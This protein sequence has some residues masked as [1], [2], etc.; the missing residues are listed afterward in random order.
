MIDVPAD[1]PAHVPA[2][3]VRPFDYHQ[4]PEFLSDPFAAFDRVRDQR[5]FFSP[6]YGGYWVLTRSEDIRLAFQNPETFSSREFSIP[7][8]VF[9]RTLRPLALDPPD[10]G[11][12]RQPLAPLFAPN[13]V[14]RREGGLREVCAGLVEGFAADGEADL[15]AALARPF[16]TTVFVSMLGLP[17]AE[18]P[19]FEAWNHDLLH[20]YDDPERR[21]QAAKNILSYLDDL[22]GR[23][24]AEG[25]RP[26]QDLFSV[27]LEA[28]VGG[29][30]LTRD[31]LLDYAFML[32]I[33][34]LDTVTASL[35]FSLHCLAVRPD[36]QALLGD[37]SSRVPAAVEELLR[38]H[39]I[40]N[41]ARVVTEDTSFAGVEMRTGDRV[42]LSTPLAGRDPYEV[43]QAEEILF[44][45]PVNRH[46]AFGAGPHRCLGSHLARLELRIALEELLARVKSFRLRDGAEV[47][48][49]GGGALGIDRLPVCWDT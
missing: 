28:K 22:V 8:G 29:R 34:G 10:H 25:P 41:T 40:I 32:F 45:R 27:L 33:A 46:L 43:D 21:Q 2:D 17:V 36:L 11:R 35:G 42:L 19:V 4:D 47:V 37:D 49:H 39:S 15:V 12:Y 48:R 26:G 6:T 30:D 1:V 14:A 24:M 20:A 3:L 9:P 13:A 18:A 38:A 7:T 16:P 23:R 31:E 44:D 5:V